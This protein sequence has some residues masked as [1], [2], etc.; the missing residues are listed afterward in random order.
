M[1]SPTAIDIQID[2]TKS[3][4]FPSVQFCSFEN[5]YVVDM[6]RDQAKYDF[7]ACFAPFFKIW[8]LERDIDYSKVWSS[9][10]ES[11]VLEKLELKNIEP[12]DVKVSTSLTIL[13]QC[14]KVET[15]G[16]FQGQKTNFEIVGKLLSR[17]LCDPSLAF[18][19]IMEKTDFAI[20][21]P[22][23]SGLVYDYTLELP[24]FDSSIKLP[25]C[26]STDKQT[27]KD[28]YFIAFATLLIPN[29]NVKCKCLP[30][31]SQNAISTFPYII[32]TKDP[33]LIFKADQ[34]EVSLNQR[35]VYDEI[36]L[37]ADIGGNL[38][39]FMGLSLLSITDIILRILQ[40]MS[41]S[42]KKNNLDRMENLILKTYFSCK[43]KY[44]T[45]NKKGKDQIVYTWTVI[46]FLCVALAIFMI[47]E[48][49]SYYFKLPTR[50]FVKL[51]YLSNVTFPSITLCGETR[52]ISHF[53]KKYVKDNITNWCDVELLD[54]Y[55]T[56]KKMTLDYLWKS[57]K[58]D[59]VIDYIIILQVPTG[60]SSFI[61]YTT[62]SHIDVLNPNI[63]VISTPLAGE[64]PIYECPNADYK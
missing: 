30:T 3:L 58:L 38:N 56:K 15:N 47:Q 19:S 27:A 37:L 29:V 32:E 45:A 26:N 51:T 21:A 61:V 55:L 16:I 60:Y 40:W 11:R 4:K 14:T 64:L 62:L 50:N 35:L 36:K 20:V 39:L 63:S 22:L 9:Q 59:P 42:S 13:G 41:K 57:T 10:N 46:L 28:S 43:R 48:R 49:A 53:K 1:S 6:L 54:L 23:F 17:K 12:D 18:S 7:V 44:N 24:F 5:D 34:M 25:H 52:R 2:S 31:Y 33:R 8:D